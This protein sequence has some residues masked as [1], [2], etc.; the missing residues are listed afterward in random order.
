MGRQI[1]SSQLWPAL[2]C[3]QGL[4][5]KVVVMAGPPAV[6]VLVGSL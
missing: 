6:S 1:N 4:L 2:S 3:E 5:E